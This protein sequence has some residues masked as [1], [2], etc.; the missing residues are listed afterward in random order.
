MTGRV[1]LVLFFSAVPQ[2]YIG[3]TKITFTSAGRKIKGKT[4]NRNCAYKRE[5]CSENICSLYFFATKHISPKILYAELHI[6]WSSAIKPDK[7]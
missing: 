4:R 6:L 3:R 1:R 5:L 7:H 2:V